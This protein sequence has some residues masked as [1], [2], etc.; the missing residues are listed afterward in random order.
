VLLNARKI[1]EADIDEL[2]IFVFDE[3]E[4]FV[5]SLEHLCS[6]RICNNWLESHVAQRNQKG[7]KHKSAPAPS[8][9]ATVTTLGTWDFSA[10]S[11]LFPAGYR[12]A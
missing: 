4:D 3:L 10:V 2:N 6:L 12:T 11:A 5:R 7:R 9:L 8:S 1:G